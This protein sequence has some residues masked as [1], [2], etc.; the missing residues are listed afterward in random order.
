MVPVEQKKDVEDLEMEQKAKKNQ[1]KKL[2]QKL[3]EIEKL[4]IK[5][6]AGDQLLPQQIEKVNRK[7]EYEARLKAL[8]AGSTSGDA[9]RKQHTS[10]LAVPRTNSDQAR[11][12]IKEFKN[13]QEHIMHKN[14]EIDELQAENKKLNASRNLILSQNECLKQR[15]EQHHNKIPRTK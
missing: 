6:K 3:K 5:Q 13:M 12:I 9:E 14:R 8:R 1:K 10:T 4:E 7:K 15:L 2:K 11:M